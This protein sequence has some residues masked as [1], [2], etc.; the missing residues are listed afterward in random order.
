MKKTRAK[1]F[2]AS[3]FSGWFRIKKLCPIR[4]KENH[5]GREIVRHILEMMILAGRDKNGIA[6][7]AFDRSVVFY[8]IGAA[9]DDDVKFVPFV[10]LLMIGAAR[11]EKFE[12]ECA[13]R[14]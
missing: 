12:F 8:Q 1:I 2:G 11:R 4:L 13:F 5:P 9:A 3:F 10:R 7:C 14:K 6:R